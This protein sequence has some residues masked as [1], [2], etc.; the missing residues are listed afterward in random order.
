MRKRY[1]SFS[2]MRLKLEKETISYNPLS[3]VMTTA[4]LV[5]CPYFLL[6]KTPSSLRKARYYFSS[7][8]FVSKEKA[9]T[10]LHGIGAAR[11]ITVTNLFFSKAQCVTHNNEVYHERGKI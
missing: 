8:G 5:L 9:R 11:M 10:R 4:S 2:T 1:D 6:A 7:Y 3:C